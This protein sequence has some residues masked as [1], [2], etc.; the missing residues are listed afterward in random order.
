M[1]SV[2]T[3]FRNSV[4][5][6]LVLVTIFG[7]SVLVRLPLL[8]KPLSHPREWLSATVLR[9][10]Q[11]WHEEGIARAHFAPITTYPGQANKNINNEALD[12]TDAEGNYFYTSFPPFAYYVPYVIF[13]MLHIYPAVLPLQIFSLALHFISGLL[14][15]CIVRLVLQCVEQPCYPAVIA[16]AVY[17]FCPVTLWLQA[18]VYMSDIF[19][20]VFFIAG[21]Y[22][23]VR[24]A[25]YGPTGISS[26]VVFGVLVFGFVYSEWLGV[27]FA[28]SV[29]VYG[30]LNRRKS[31]MKG[32]LAAAALG[33]GAA[34]GLTV[35]QYSGI[36][37]FHS[38]W[39]ASQNRFLLRSGIG[40]Q[41]D[42]NLHL[43]SLLG[44][45]LVLTYYLLA[46]TTDFALLALWAALKNRGRDLTVSRDTKMALFFGA[47]LP[48]LLHHLVFF[49]FT[50]AHEFSVL[51]A[52][53]FIAITAG[54]LAWR[55]WESAPC[56]RISTVVLRS[57]VCFSVVLCCLASIFEYRMLAGPSTPAYKEIG[58]FIAKNAG[59]DEIVFAEY[60]RRVQDSGRPL[61][62]IVLY[63]H[64]NVAVW[65]DENQARQ[66]ARL[67]GVPKIVVFEIDS[68]ETAVSAVRRMRF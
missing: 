18:N 21:I 60:Q 8:N 22:L 42:L 38:F 43:W 56:A 68:A 55:L 53:P 30:W 62:Q 16:F 46:Y 11:I 13:E 57:V 32:L 1:S 6:G 12:H 54:L 64:R 2:A 59:P 31:G 20:Q 5:A 47:V 52:A 40:A 44:W 36:S 4:F 3:P 37:G 25:R 28:S 26:Y 19:A 23:L 66:L 17:I 34:L 63:A 41:L 61:P 10:L 24:W 39:V 27:F 14:I 48:V 29:V 65:Q 7:A 33:A 49:N 51:K 58:D 45:L 67:N 35:W 50:A 9:H 15:Y